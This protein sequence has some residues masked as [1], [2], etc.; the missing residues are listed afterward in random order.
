MARLIVTKA[1]YKLALLSIVATP[2]AY[3]V[4]QRASSGT[5]KP[6]TSINLSAEATG[7]SKWTAVKRAS[8][9]IHSGSYPIMLNLVPVSG[10]PDNPYFIKLSNPKGGVHN[11]WEIRYL[12][13]S[14]HQIASFAVGQFTPS[15]AV[16]V[17][18]PINLT[19]IDSPPA[20]QHSYVLQIRYVGDAP[21]DV[22]PKLEISNAR[23]VASNL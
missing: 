2:D 6:S 8:A 21:G 9:T 12:R 11:R 10:A 14:T 23:L 15:V 1:L 13:D 5:L 17:A 22:P 3:T 20:G 4:A 18:V 7:Y 16:N 19:A